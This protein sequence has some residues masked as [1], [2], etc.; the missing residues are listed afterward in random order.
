MNPV[1][2][3]CLF[4]FS[5]FLV[6]CKAQDSQE[7]GRFI[8]F[9][10]MG[11][12]RSHLDSHSDFVFEL[13][14]LRASAEVGGFPRVV[15]KIKELRSLNSRSFSIHTGDALTGNIYYNLFKGQADAVMMNEVCF[16]ALLL[17]N[18]EMDLYESGLIKF[19]EFLKNRECNTPVLSANIIP[20]IGVSKLARHE[21]DEYLRPYIVRRIDNQRLAFIGISNLRKSINSGL[22]NAAYGFLDEAQAAQGYINLLK[23]RGIT[24]FVI[25]SDQSY[26]QDIAL[27]KKLTDVDVIIGG[28]SRVLLGEFSQYGLN[29]DEPYPTIVKNKD[30][31]QVCIVE[32]WRDSLAVGELRVRFD[33]KGSI[34]E[35]SGKMNLLVANKPLKLFDKKANKL[36]EAKRQKQVYAVLKDDPQISFIEESTSTR[37]KLDAFSVSSFRDRKVG[38]A[39]EN[40]CFDWF[41]GSG[42][43][44]LC[45]KEETAQNGSDITNLVAQ[46]FL[47]FIPEADIAIQN[48]GGIRADIKKGDVTLGDIYK[49]LPYINKLMLLKMSGQQIKDV[50]EDAVEFSL[51][52]S[53]S[54]G[55]YPYAANLRWQLYA[56]NPKGSRV[57]KLEYKSKESQAWQPLDSE[58]VFIVVT[59]DFIGKGND[60]YTI[61]SQ[62]KHEN[63]TNT[64]LEYSEVF[65]EYLRTKQN[66]EKLHPSDYSTQAYY[67]E[68][69][70]QNKETNFNR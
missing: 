31:D 62:I 17:G 18:H 3:V 15:K 7:Q 55:A 6:A 19:L 16:D 46:S 50:L 8:S 44:R 61:M 27:A 40:L 5:L 57:N 21:R 23:K 70:V 52:K 28:D 10:H 29:N 41:P 34:A 54:K 51:S 32:S 68:S 2:I 20:K 35:C 60:G 9:L 67:L 64:H 63:R 47:T 58:K 39:L 59:N 38:R 66:I 22:V 12:H 37:K 30:G 43:S 45:S 53:G 65:I 56:A 13:G 4:I 36:D 14:E 1:Y 11:D 69:P 48:A 33:D 49:L 25:I 26:A 42:E 24:R